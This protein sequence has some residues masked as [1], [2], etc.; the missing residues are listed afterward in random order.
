MKKQA[1]TT[2][3]K[4]VKP[5]VATAPTKSPL[6]QAF[7][8][9]GFVFVRNESAD[10]G[11][12]E[13]YGFAH[14]DGDV[15]LLVV[16][17]GHQRWLLRTGNGAEQKGKTAKEFVAALHAS[18]SV[19]LPAHV[20]GALLLLQK[21]TKGS[22][23]IADLAGDDNYTARI[24]LLKKLKNTDKILVKE[25]GVNY[26]IAS[27]YKALSIEPGTSK[28][29]EASA[30]A[31]KCVDLA[32]QANRT[33]SA[34]RTAEKSEI[35]VARKLAMA[36]N[37]VLDGKPILDAPK[38]LSRAQEAASSAKFK[39]E[40]A[41]R[42]ARA[43]REAMT[44]AIAAPRADAKVQVNIDEVR[45]LEDPRNGII[46][47]QLEKSNSQGAICV[48]NNGS[49][50]CAGVVPTEDFNKLRPLSSTDIVKD[51]NQLL[52]PINA[53]VVVTPV[54]ASH[55]T[56][57]LEYCKENIAMATATAE[58]TKKFAAPST[59]AKKSVVPAAA[60]K[61]TVKASE[62][63]E[64]APRA[65]RS[66]ITED[67]T[68]KILTKEDNPYRDGTKARSSFELL[69]KSKTFGEYTKLTEKSKADVYEALYFA[70]W[71]SQPHGKAPAYIKLG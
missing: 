57:I 64:K 40:L 28:A 1:A 12:S 34:V 22:Y 37:I 10:E 14:P 21:Y 8:R 31:A 50:V 11:R 47:L 4:S 53:G 13:A 29:A 35:A 16:G 6:T 18:R 3:K 65:G 60:A 43:E 63:V 68:I 42:V 45:L 67:T 26:L 48:Y 23:R 36:Q 66:S 32:K 19:A 55:L 33:A 59:A 2:S 54:A 51:V 38:K 30:F 17:V 62:A 58:K 27:F 71:A 49:R 20:Q 70:K 7:N 39:A 24:Q 69:K 25:S 61:K 15:A 41:A 46:L 44:A 9:A 5:A 52:H 56:A